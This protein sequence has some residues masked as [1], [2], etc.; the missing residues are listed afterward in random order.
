LA[1]PV[2]W[3]TGIKLSHQTIEHGEVFQVAGHVWVHS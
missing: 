2:G 1:G 3:A